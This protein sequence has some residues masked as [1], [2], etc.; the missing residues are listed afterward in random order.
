MAAV[1]YEPKG[2]LSRAVHGFEETAIAVLIGLM[3]IIT[4]I[5][6]PVRYLFDGIILPRLEF[7]WAV[8]MTGF[9]FAWLVILGTSYAV[10][11]SANLGVDA[12][13]NLLPGTV[14]RAVA[15]FA[16]GI[17]IAYA[18]LILKGAWDFWAPFANLP[19]TTGRW[20]PTGF[21]DQFLVQG[22]YE[23]NDV[24][25]PAWLGFLQDWFNEGEEYEKLPRVLP[26][27]M[28]PIGFALFLLR[29]IQATL[30][31]WRGEIDHLIAS[32]EAEDLV[33]AAVA[34]KSAEAAEAGAGR[35]GG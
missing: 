20:F 8:E 21:Q 13:I 24:P 9:L 4:F 27:I 34:A 10:K 31:L 29:L 14:R 17:C 12:L 30:R 11:V 3:T 2:G 15:F 33:E 6:V 26:Y 1:K 7:L 5:N 22:W 25:M 16:A 28:L 18:L 35:R 19:P 23:V 32:H